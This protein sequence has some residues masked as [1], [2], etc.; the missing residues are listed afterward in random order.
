MRS[1]LR[2]SRTACP[3]RRNSGFD[4][5][6]TPSAR[7]PASDRTRCT[8][9]VEPTG[10]VDLLTTT[11]FGART[12]AISRATFSTKVRSAAPSAPWGVC[13]QR[14]T[15]SAFWAAVAAP[16]HELEAVRG[17]ALLD[18][19]G[20]TELEDRDLPFFRRATRSA[21]MSAQRTSWPRW[22]K[23]AAVVSPT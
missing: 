7:A 21:S 19:L 2:K 8:K 9:R 11:V 3:S 17:Q 15:I 5:T 18:E 6:V 13:T 12:G 1:G 10:T 23:Q 14:N 20:Q 22:A 16:D 4:A